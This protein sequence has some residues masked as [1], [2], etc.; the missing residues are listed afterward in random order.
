MSRPQDKHLIP[1]TERSEEEAYAIRSA[2]GKA[3]KVQV[4]AEKVHLSFL[5]ISIY[6]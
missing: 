2:G 4:G 5:P 1:L 3:N 6:S